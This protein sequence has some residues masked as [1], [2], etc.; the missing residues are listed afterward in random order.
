MNI[1]DDFAEIIQDNARMSQQISVL[2]RMIEEAE[3]EEAIFCRKLEYEKVSYRPQV[4]TNKIR[5]IFGWENSAEAEK[6]M[7]SYEPKKKEEKA[8]EHNKAVF[9]DLSEEELL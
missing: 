8:E 1:F 5:M 9:V 2:K 6:I 4:N 3:V 7:N